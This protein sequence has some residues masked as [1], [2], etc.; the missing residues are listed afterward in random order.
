MPYAVAKSGTILI[1]SGPFED[2][3]RLH[4]FVVCTDV[5]DEGK[6]LLVSIASLINSLCD[7]TCIIQPHEHP[8]VKHPSYVFYRKSLIQPAQ[9][10]NDAVEKGLFKPKENMNSQTLLRIR[11]GV[12]NSP[13]TPKRIKTYRGCA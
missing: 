9:A 13:Q 2:P 7:Q 4:L 6:H 12:C 3:D 11:N 1:P 10:I 5:C 8:F